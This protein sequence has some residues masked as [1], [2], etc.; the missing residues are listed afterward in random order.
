MA[1]ERGIKHL[2]FAVL[3]VFIIAVLLA[4]IA[5][6]KLILGNIWNLALIAVIIAFLVAVW[7]FDFLILLTEY[8]RAVIYRFGKVKRVGGPG[9][10][11]MVPI[12]EN[13]TMVDLR[14]KTIDVPKQDVIT[15]DS[16]ELKVD[17]IIYL[18]VNS[19]PQSVINSV[20][21]V[22]DYREAVRLYVVSSIRDIMGGMNLS[23]IIA[24][25]YKLNTKLKESL[26]VVSRNWGV[27]IEAVEIKDVD[28]PKVVMDAMHAE[29]AA[30][31]EKLARIQ[32]AEAQ[33]A[34]IEAV[35]S[36][37]EGLS[38]NAITYYYIKALEEMSKGQSTKIYFPVELSRLAE[39]V[40]DTLGRS[41]TSAAASAPSAAAIEKIAA[42]YKDL[43]Q[44]FV[45]NAVKKAIKK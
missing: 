45:D 2:V 5:N 42:P 26:S 13:Y 32:K 9:W 15:S 18:K 23:E 36:A 10:A 17:A 20:V 41:S 22:E 34:E 6:A 25:I 33:R 31:Q 43:I 3:I 38:R 30:T 4:S 44:E 27:G 24:N 19:D 14:T 7:K 35:K 8:E 12:I 39:S 1:S 40:S 16:I 37:T 11:F 21:E 29:K 28:V